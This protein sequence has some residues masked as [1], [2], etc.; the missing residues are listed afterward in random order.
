MDGA[1]VVAQEL[2]ECTRQWALLAHSL[3]DLGRTARQVSGHRLPRQLRRGETAIDP[4]LTWSRRGFAEDHGRR[5]GFLA[6]H[7]DAIMPPFFAPQAAAG[8]DRGPHAAP[9]G[10]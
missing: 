10:G 6:G 1:I 9:A 3:R 7:R 2:D 4:D 8:D 5:A